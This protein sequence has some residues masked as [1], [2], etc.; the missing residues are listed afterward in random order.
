[1]KWLFMSAAIAL[2]C[3]VAA[4][5]FWTQLRRIRRI[6]FIR[7]YA[8]PPGLL[9]RLQAKHKGF[10]RKESALVANGLRQFFLA[11]L[12]SGRRYVAMPSQVVDD[13]WHEFILYTR[14]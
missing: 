3:A 4:A 6:E 9:D 12:M 11:Y 1:M 14:A 13:L 8:W 2:A 5:C 10:T 7:A